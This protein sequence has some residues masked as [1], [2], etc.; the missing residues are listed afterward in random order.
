MKTTS[1]VRFVAYFLL[2]FVTLNSTSADVRGGTEK[3]L[4]SVDQ[5]GKWGFINEQ[6][7]LVIQP[8]FEGV[9]YFSEGVAAVR[10]NGKYG[11]NNRSGKI[12]S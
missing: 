12:C 6:G 8:A 11:Y 5:N 2:A 9:S 3:D 4:Y 10:I 1:K 7:Q